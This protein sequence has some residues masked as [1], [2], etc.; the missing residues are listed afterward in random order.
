MRERVEEAVGESAEHWARYIVE[1]MEATKAEA[2]KD[3]GD[4]DIRSPEM[5]K[6]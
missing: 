4:E 6:R 1:S 5:A 2:N 3:N